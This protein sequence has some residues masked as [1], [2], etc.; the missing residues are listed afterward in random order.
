MTLKSFAEDTR[1]ID[2]VVRNIEII[3]EAVKNIPVEWLEM[4]PEIEWKRI[5]RLRDIIVHR[6]F[7]VELEVVWAIVQVRIEEL[8]ESVRSLLDDLETSDSK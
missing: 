3:G 7:R 2:A 5:A 1:T 6:S 4:R 8:R